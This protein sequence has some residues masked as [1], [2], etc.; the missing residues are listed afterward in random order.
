MGAIVFM[1]ED[2][3]QIGKDGIIADDARQTDL[4]VAI[5]EA[6]DQRIGKARSVRSRGRPLAQ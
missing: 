4:L 6:E 2:I 3:A 5:I 1:D